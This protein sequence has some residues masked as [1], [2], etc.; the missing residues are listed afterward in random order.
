MCEFEGR[1]GE[2]GTLEGQENGTGQIS[3]EW[4]KYDADFIQPLA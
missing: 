3:L 4:E 2:E 1:W